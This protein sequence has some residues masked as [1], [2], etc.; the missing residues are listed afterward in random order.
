MASGAFTAYFCAVKSNM[1]PMS[2]N[3][4]VLTSNVAALRAKSTKRSAQQAAKQKILPPAARK[5]LFFFCIVLCATPY[6]SA[7]VA[8]LGDSFYISAG[9]SFPETER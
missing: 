3:S 2:A 9:A 1:I 5:A 4:A 8:L 7:P 6:L